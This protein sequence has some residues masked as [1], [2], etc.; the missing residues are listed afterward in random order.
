MTLQ[1]LFALLAVFAGAVISLRLLARF[2][3]LR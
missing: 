2:L 1:P 3:G